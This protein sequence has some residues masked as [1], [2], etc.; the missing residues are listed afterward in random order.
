MGLVPVQLR[1]H[2]KLNY[3]PVYKS[4]GV[5]PAAHLLEQFLVMSLSA[6]DY[7]RQQVAFAAG[8]AGDYKLNYLLVRV[9]DHLQAG[10]RGISP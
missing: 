8:I 5:A 6:A 7:R 9:A 2:L 10:L 4:L 3:F 1:N